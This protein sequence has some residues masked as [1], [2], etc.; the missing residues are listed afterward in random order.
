MQAINNEIELLDAQGLIEKAKEAI[1]VS[2]KELAALIQASPDQVYRWKKSKVEMPSVFR[3]GLISIIEMGRKSSEPAKVIDP[4]AEHFKEVLA[5]FPF[6]EGYIQ[7]EDALSESLGL[8]GDFGF[9][10]PKDFESAGRATRQQAVLILTGYCKSY[11]SLMTWIDLFLIDKNRATCPTDEDVQKTAAEVVECLPQLAIAKM[12]LSPIFQ[13]SINREIFSS[14]SAGAR[15]AMTIAV[16]KFLRAYLKSGNPIT[17]D[18]FRILSAANDNLDFEVNYF[19]QNEDCITQYFTLAE[20]KMMR[21]Q[22][23]IKNLISK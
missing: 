12:D 7:N 2:Q 5:S 8:L 15:H 6:M 20:R 13:A 16:K 14:K 1:S 19:R 10:F 3:K 11:N 22:T 23:E 21:K 17:R 18:V 4:L 9:V